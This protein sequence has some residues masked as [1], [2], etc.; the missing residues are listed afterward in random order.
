[1][2][3]ETLT[4]ASTSRYVDTRSWRLHYNEAGSGHPLVLLHGSGAGATGWSNFAPN[5]PAL[6]KS[7]RVIALDAPGWGSS[8]PGLPEDYD[9]PNA[10][11]E[12]LDA[13]GIE[14]AALVGNS[15]GG[16]TAITFASRYPDRISHLVTMGAGSLMDIPTMSGAG[17]GPSEGLKIL[18]QAY[19]EPTLENM[20]KVAQ[21]MT[22]DSAKATPELAQQRLDNA[23][24]NPVHLENFLKGLA[25]GGPARNRATHQ[26]IAGIKAPTLLIH[27]R[28]DR[29]VHYEY[30][31]RI[32]PMIANARLV[33]LNRCGH[34]AQL[35]HT[36]E[37]N[38]LVTD[39]IEHG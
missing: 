37:F 16:S 31:L 35:E 1:M 32:L 5:I 22:F 11:L 12:L 15:L 38:R 3:E 8:S 33:L 4:E 2:S 21:I 30:S 29:V 14:R 28:D 7:F 9:H 26:E 10:V 27:G 39:F 24:A 13:L 36:D 25:T 18:F 20:M 34:W 6:A 17:D 23:L 19:R